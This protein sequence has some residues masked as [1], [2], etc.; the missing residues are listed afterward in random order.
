MADDHAHQLSGA[1]RD[2]DARASGDV[3]GAGV[4]VVKSPAQWHGEGNFQVHAP[5][6][7][8]VRAGFMILAVSNRSGRVV[9]KR[10]RLW[11]S[12]WKSAVEKV[13]LRVPTN[14]GSGGVI[15]ISHNNQWLIPVIPGLM[16]VDEKSHE[17]ARVC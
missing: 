15:R 17:D 10:P 6:V 16:P 7:S 14:K 4:Q 13:S 1:E 5:V 8:A 11:I 12:L 9:N 3:L 2:A